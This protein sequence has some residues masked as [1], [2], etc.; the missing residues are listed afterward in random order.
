MCFFLQE[1][2]HDIGVDS[3]KAI[4]YQIQKASN[5]YMFES[6]L[7][8]SHYLAFKHDSSGNFDKL[9][10]RLPADEPDEGLNI[11]LEDVQM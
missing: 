4:F 11:T 5:V 10:L 1:I 6:S 3:H 2:P 9:T 8:K 7:Y